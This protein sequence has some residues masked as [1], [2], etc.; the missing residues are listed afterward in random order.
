MISH[1]L[2]I[3]ANELNAHLVDYYGV[4]S[5]QV[6]LGNLSEGVATGAGGDLSRDMLYLSVV[7]IQ[8]EKTL[9]NL[10]HRIPD[11]SSLKATYENPPVFI[12][13]YILVTATHTNYAVALSRLSRAIRFFQQNNVF[14]QD[15][16][17]PNSISD[18]TVDELDRLESFKLIFD[19][20][21]PSMEEVNH[22]WGTLGG[23]QYPFV[24]YMLR[25][26]DL[27]FKKKNSES[28]RLIE[29]V[30]STFSFKE[31]GNKR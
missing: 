8:E 13:L 21:S 3:T 2:S 23:K 7:N 5:G 31:D 29:T 17:D 9:K 4:D 26:L 28:R 10:P 20:Y 18:P 6:K 12:N 22:L 15:D 30:S 11:T 25:M 16:V 1:A 24:L 19:L 27:K 14:T